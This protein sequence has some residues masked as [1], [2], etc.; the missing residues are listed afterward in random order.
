MSIIHGKS[1]IND[2]KYDHINILFILYWL[3]EVKTANLRIIIKQSLLRLK[4]SVNQTKR[5]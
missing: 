5:N 3:D 1:F 4:Y 2:E